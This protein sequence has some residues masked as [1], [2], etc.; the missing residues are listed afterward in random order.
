MISAI[1]KYLSELHKQI[2]DCEVE[3][4]REKNKKRNANKATLTKLEGYL[5]NHKWHIEHLE[6]ILRQLDNKILDAYNVEPTLDSIDEYLDNYRDKGYMFDDSIYDEFDLDVSLPESSSSEE[7]EEEEEKEEKEL[8][9]KKET[10]EP[11]LKS[12]ASIPSI[13]PLTAMQPKP[14]TVPPPK[15]SSPPI[16]Y[17]QAIQRASTRT[18][19]SSTHAPPPKSPPQAIR[20]PAQPTIKSS[21]QPTIK[22]SPQPPVKPIASPQQPL[23]TTPSFVP[24]TTG[25]GDVVLWNMSE[26]L[27]MLAAATAT[28]TPCPRCEPPYFPM[29]PAAVPDS[30]PQTPLR[31]VCE[32]SALRQL[33]DEELLFAF[34]YPVNESQRTAAARALGEKEWRFC[35]AQKA[36]YREVEVGVEAESKR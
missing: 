30:F 32:G 17:A 12:V 35:S 15:I 23:A 8:K 10:K 27:E 6:Q 11:P 22:S 26:V 36:W 31:G 4:K 24:P 13:P 9:E 16:N 33:P 3:A 5:R 34:A 29:C 25:T 21:P 1:K 20:S 14:K 28:R 2:D 18:S 19:E 7:E